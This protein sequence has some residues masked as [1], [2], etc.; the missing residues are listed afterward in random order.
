[1][2]E[3]YVNSEPL[4]VNDTRHRKSGIGPEQRMLASLTASTLSIVLINFLII[5]L[6]KLFRT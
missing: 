5:R 3:Y 2:A 4:E 1:M 6:V